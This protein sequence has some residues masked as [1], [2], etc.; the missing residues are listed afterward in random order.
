MTTLR[1]DE[2]SMAKVLK[3]YFSSVF[4][5][6]SVGYSINT[7]DNNNNDTTSNVSV[8]ERRDVTIELCGNNNVSVNNDNEY[9]YDDFQ[10]YQ[11][12]S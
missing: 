2:Q 6:A 1:P 4:S 3:K 8:L 5:T 9:R 7:N 12:S 10:N 11:S